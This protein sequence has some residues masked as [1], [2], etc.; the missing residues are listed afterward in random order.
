MKYHLVNSF[1]TMSATNN[2]ASGAI[3]HGSGGGSQPDML[4]NDDAN[5]L[6]N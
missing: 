2:T 6:G 3:Y 4:S 1:E 5:T